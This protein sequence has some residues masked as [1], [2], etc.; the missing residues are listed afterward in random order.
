MIRPGAAPEEFGMVH[1]QEHR[2]L[3]AFEASAEMSD[4]L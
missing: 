3:G 2:D 4:D 1:R